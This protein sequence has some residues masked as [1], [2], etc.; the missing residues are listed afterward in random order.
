MGFKNVVVIIA[1]VLLLIILT[2]FAINTYYTKKNTSYPPVKSNCPDHWIS[3]KQ[4]K[5]SICVNQKD[6]G[7][8]SCSKTMDFTG[9]KWSGPNGLCKK[10]EWAKGCDLTWDGVTNSTQKC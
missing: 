6:L 8:S 9:N 3:K 2:L 1:V 10:K 4:G 5:K 7:S